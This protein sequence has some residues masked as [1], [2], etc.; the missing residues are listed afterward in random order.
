MRQTLGVPY[1]IG[2]L[3]WLYNTAWFYKKNHLS[4]LVVKS[5]VIIFVQYSSLLFYE[6]RFLMCVCRILQE[7]VNIK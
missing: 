1:V 4:T 2:C 7:N 6:N 5:R 3:N